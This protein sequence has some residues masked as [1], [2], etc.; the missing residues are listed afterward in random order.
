MFQHI[1]LLPQPRPLQVPDILSCEILITEAC[2][3]FLIL[4]APPLEIQTGD[5]HLPPP[6][7]R[8]TI[9]TPPLGMWDGIATEGVVRW[10]RRCLGV[11]RRRTMKPKVCI[12]M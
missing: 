5:S 10:F 9:R 2:L 4:T 1:K 12:Y 11:M 8:G 3:Q 7:P 6:G